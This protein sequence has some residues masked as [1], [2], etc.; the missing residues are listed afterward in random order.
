M[1]PIEELVAEL[2]LDDGLSTHYGRYKAKVSLRA[3]RGRPPRGKLILV[4]GMTPTPHGEGKTVV[5]I[6]L[7]MGLSKLGRLAVA[8]IRQPSLGPVFGIKGGGAGGGK[9]TLEPMRD[10]N[11][12]LTGDIDAITCAHNLL[13]ATIDNHIFH[14]NSLG[15]DPEAILWPRTLDVEDRALREVRVAMGERNGT[16][17]EDKFI[18][19]AASEVMAILCLSRDYADLK[20]RLGRM[21]VAYT[22]DGRPVTAAEMKVVGALGA[23]LK[24]ALEPNL[25]QTCEGT[26]ALV[27]GGPFGN[28]AHGTCSIISIILALQSSDYAVVEAGFGSDLGAEKFVDIVTRV[29]GVGVDAA[30]I[31]ATLRAL[32]HH[33]RGG[34]GSA[35][36]P[37]GP[38]PEAVRAGLVNLA[39]HIENVRT[40]G[41][42]PVVALNLFEGDG[43][44]EVAAVSGFCANEG[45]PF[46]TT[47]AYAEGGEGSRRLAQIVVEE[48]GH[49]GACVPVY[50]PDDPVR[51]KV[52]K[53][54]DR[55]Y[56]GS[57]VSYT[58]AA[59][60]ELDKITR[61]GYG[62]LPVCI[63]KT[64]N[65]L[66]DDARVVGRPRGFV[67]AVHD[68]ELA[69]GA[70]YVI[71]EMGEISRMPGLPSSPGAE[72]ISLSDDG[73]V[74]GV[75]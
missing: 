75:V 31:V 45:V 47:S 50:E 9:S 27:H 8:C 66:S 35:A 61:L 62:R 12:R 44:E 3:L 25:V 32:R 14:G 1:R 59:E 39:K 52:S 28:I 15:I 29:A 49:G 5:S 69:A 4:T 43:D 33:G 63:A 2:G 30:V 53:V 38:D 41:L 57:G 6:G 58:A 70:G 7:A 64:A 36:T 20:S 67:A 51:E 13:A 65:S 55:M 40:L 24:E 26:P 54:V 23:L 22:R 48:S 34:E 73:V 16:P 46:S 74:S 18:I 19:T 21:V 72:R 37:D 68:V 60:A 42:R 56:G 71:V 10:V 17:H 11:M